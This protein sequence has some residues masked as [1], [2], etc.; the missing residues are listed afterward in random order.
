MVLS[1]SN[2]IMVPRLITRKLAYGKAALVKINFEAEG[3]SLLCTTS[4]SFL[5]ERGWLAI[6]EVNPGDKIMRVNAASLDQCRVKSIVPTGTREP[7]FNL[8]TQTEH[9]F[10]VDGCV[11]HNFT[12]FRFARVILHRLLFDKVKGG[13]GV[14]FELNFKG[15]EG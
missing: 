13:K 8:Y 10:I 1:Y 12:H 4:H 14:S 11:A 3:N 2:G 15:I 5:T 6:K 7:V 9:N